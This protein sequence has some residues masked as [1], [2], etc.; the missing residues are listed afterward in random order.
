MCK[1]IYCLGTEF[2]R[3]EDQH[4]I[5]SLLTAPTYDE[6]LARRITFTQ[7]PFW[8]YQEYVDIFKAAWELNNSLPEN[9]VKFRIL[10]LNE[11]PEWWHVKTEEDRESHEV[12]KKVWHGGD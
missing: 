8:G 9:Y 2:A 12:M 11:S 1:G 4:L 6:D 3:S 7:F 5:D 10:G